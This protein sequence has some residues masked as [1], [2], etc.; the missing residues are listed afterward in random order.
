MRGCYFDKSSETDG[1]GETR[2]CLE[3]N[4]RDFYDECVRCHVVVEK[5]VVDV[6]LRKDH[7]EYYYHKHECV[8][9]LFLVFRNNVTEFDWAWVETKVETK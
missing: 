6:L 7:L 1:K 2:N 5:H 9:Y 8:G 4:A 3:E